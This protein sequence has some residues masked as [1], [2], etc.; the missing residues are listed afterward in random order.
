MVVLILKILLVLYALQGLVKP[1]MHFIISKERR[2]K[3]AEAMY[4]KKGGEANAT[5][6]TD[7]MLYLF[8]LILLGLLAASG[9]EYLNFTTGFL[10]GLTALQLYFHAFN[11]PLEK[12]PALPLTPIKMMS[13][14]IKE[15]PAKAWVSTLFMSAILLWCL[16]LLG[17]HF[18]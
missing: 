1:L 3:M 17:M 16:V 8:C 6:L 10:V 7:G 14:A 9:I 15:M 4:T 5:K 2:M 18:L 12:Q 11:Q 13:Y